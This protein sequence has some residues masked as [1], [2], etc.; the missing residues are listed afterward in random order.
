MVE[1]APD[2]LSSLGPTLSRH[3][4]LGSRR[5]SAAHWFAYKLRRELRAGDEL[6]P[7]VIDGV[8]LAL[9]AEFARIPGVRMERLAPRWLERA[10]A[11]LHEEFVT[12]PSLDRLAVEAGVHRAHLARAFRKHYGCTIGDYVRQRR[13]AHACHRLSMT[14]TPI[15]DIA[16]DA[17]FADQ[18]HFTT[19]FKRL[20]GATPGEFR[21]QALVRR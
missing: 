19:T 18:S 12:P 3:D 15:S 5:H 4:R 7:L 9:L 16:L 17:G 20:V 6:A 8:G 14:D 2:V 11:Q 1:I 13:I 21:S 10:R